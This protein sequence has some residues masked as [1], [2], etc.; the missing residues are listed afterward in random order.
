VYRE[1]SEVKKVDAAQIIG[2]AN[3]LIQSYNEVIRVAKQTYAEQMSEFQELSEVPLVLI[4]ANITLGYK[5]TGEVSA[6][7]TNAMITLGFP[8]P[9]ESQPP[10]QSVPPIQVN[11]I[12][13]VNQLT[14]INFD[15]L[16]EMIQQ[17]KTVPQETRDAAA[18]A[19]KEFNDEIAKAKPEPSKLKSC[20]DSV[21][22]VG[23]QFG[24]PLLFKILEN[25]N[26]IFISLPKL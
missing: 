10:A 9:Q 26:K 19:V 20:L 14:N 2:R 8:T 17:Q 1:A 15:Q 4:P 12:Q 22:E 11:V 13:Q 16:I 5:R 18:N 23:T 7:I 25:W 21:L 6:K 3:A 24:I